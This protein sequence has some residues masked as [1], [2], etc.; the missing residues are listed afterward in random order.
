MGYNNSLS[1][2]SPYVTAMTI[3]PGPLV[4]IGPEDPIYPLDISAPGQ[5]VIRLVS[6]NADYGSV[7]E[8]RN[9]TTTAGTVGAINFVNA[10]GEYAGQIAYK[11]LNAL[12]FQTAGVERMSIISDGKVGIGTVMPQYTLDV[13][14]VIRA[15]N[16]SPSD[17]RL[18]TEI[19][20]LSEALDT[21]LALRGVTYRW[22]REGFPEKHL[23][24]GRQIGLIAQEVEKV[25]PEV[26]STD[27]QGLKSLSYQSLV[28]VLVEAL[29]EQQKEIA[30]KDAR[31]ADQ[32]R[33]IEQLERDRQA[34]ESRLR[35]L[36]ERAGE[37]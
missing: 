31:L 33:R 6:H 2:R 27:G 32:G 37:R 25:L 8:L 1:F 14:G 5:G 26:V 13:A 10:N 12:T 17:A 11:G 29:K 15:N 28:P 7:L 18:K 30:E 36:E 4:G 3:K 9:T 24:E 23:P 20:P 16:V 35:R 21:V 22:D 19:A 34:T